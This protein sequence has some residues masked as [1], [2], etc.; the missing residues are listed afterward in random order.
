MAAELLQSLK[1][2][3]AYLT[4]QQK[5]LKKA[6]SLAACM[7]Q[8]AIAWQ[9]KLKAAK[10]T[11]SE[12]EDLLQ[13]LAMG[14]WTEP[15]AELLGTAI[16]Q[17]VLGAISKDGKPGKRPPQTMK[18]FQAYL[19]KR[20]MD[21]L[22]ST[23]TPMAAKV[24]QVAARC[25]QL[26]LMWP[27]E[28]SIRH[29]VAVAIGAGLEPGDRTPAAIFEVMKEFKRVLRNMRSKITKSDDC[30]DG[31]LVEYPNTPQDLAKLMATYP[32][33]DPPVPCL[34]LLS[35]SACAR[36]VPRFL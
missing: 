7:E 35:T 1:E 33:S 14:P 9:A 28:I 24:D 11:A 3:Q 6:G 5:V 8:Q 10:V 34:K 20:D 22:S 2:V 26:G 31:Y 15:Q 19:T 17:A 21:V 18:N 30:L 29:I 36:S 13:V 32:D 23:P 16:N 27:N 12:A 25:V 4:S